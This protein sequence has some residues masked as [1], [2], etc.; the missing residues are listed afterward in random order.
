MATSEIEKLAKKLRKD[1]K[2]D[3]IIN[4]LTNEHK[5]FPVISTGNLYIDWALCCGGIP[6]GFVVELFGAES[7]GKTTLALQIA[8]RA[9]RM[10]YIVLFVDVEQDFDPS[11]AR[12]LGVN[13]ENFMLCQPDSGEQAMQMI[14]NSM[15]HSSSPMFSILDSIAGMRVGSQNKMQVD[16]V[17]VA[18]EARLVSKSMKILRPLVKRTGSVAIFTNQI[19]EKMNVMW[20]NPETTPGGRALKHAAAIRMEIRSGKKIKNSDKT[21]ELGKEVR[22]T[23][24]KNK[25]GVPWRKAVFDFMYDVGSDTQKA[26]LDCLVFNKLAKKSRG[27]YKCQGCEGDVYD[28]YKE[29]GKKKRKFLRRKALER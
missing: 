7:G 24:V 5:K 15:E 27:V 19:R 6:K 23:I 3:E 8:A 4:L 25:V 28:V 22:V 13:L 14:I 17:G 1:F 16:K 2:D 10:G 21:R 18:E 9:Q 11:Y 12:T 29:L 26:F 20:G